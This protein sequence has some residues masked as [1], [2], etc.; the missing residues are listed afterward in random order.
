MLRSQYP[1][2]NMQTLCSQAPLG[3]SCSLALIEFFALALFAISHVLPV[4][5]VN[6]TSVLPLSIASNPKWFNWGNML[7]LNIDFQETHIKMPNLIAVFPY[8]GNKQTLKKGQQRSVEFSS[9]R[10]DIS[11]AL[12]SIMQHCISVYLLTSAEVSHL[13]V[14]HK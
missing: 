10:P 9:K 2:N 7:P 12:N 4:F 5:C 11:T 8:C 13:I 14:W 6:G 1:T 3:L